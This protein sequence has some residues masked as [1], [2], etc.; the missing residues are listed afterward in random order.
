ML[1]RKFNS[2]EPEIGKT[3]IVI[4]KNRRRQYGTV[5]YVGMGSNSTG[6]SR[7]HSITI[8]KHSESPNLSEGSIRTNNY[9]SVPEALENII[10][11]EEVIIF[12]NWQDV[13][14]FLSQNL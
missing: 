4:W 5:V 9:S 11:L 6:D 14:L 2:I 13:A 12:D 1:V 8:Q 10:G 3:D 7:F